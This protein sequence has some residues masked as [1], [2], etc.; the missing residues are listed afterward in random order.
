MIY[1]AG[2][3]AHRFRKKFPKLGVPTK[4]LPSSDTWLG[5]ISRGNCIHPEESFLT[6]TVLMDAEFEKFHSSGLSKELKIFDKLTEIICNKI[7]GD[8]S[9][10]VIACF[11]RTRTYIRLRNINIKIKEDNTMRKLKKKTKHI[12]NKI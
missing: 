7:S 12:C 10:E 5:C 1:V 3:V 11:V 4:L 6:A 2:Y 9:R 8:F